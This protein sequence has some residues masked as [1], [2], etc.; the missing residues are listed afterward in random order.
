LAQPLR[1]ANEESLGLTLRFQGIECK[2]HIG[3][4]VVC[5]RADDPMRQ[6]AGLVAE[7]LARLI[8]LLGDLGGR[9][10]VLQVDRSEGQA[11]TREGLR[12]VIPA[13]LLH[14]LFQRFGDQLL[15]FLGRGPRPGGDHGHLLDRERGVFCPAQSQE[16]HDAGD[17]DRHDQEQSDRALAYGE[18]GEVEGAHCCPPLLTATLWA[19]APSA[20]RTCSPSC[21]RSAPSTTTRL[22]A[23][24]PP[25]PVAASSL[26]PVTCTARQVTRGAFPSTSHTPGPLPGSKIAPI[27]T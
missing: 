26:R 23:L 4:F 12:P 19:A 1:L 2:G 22:P 25:T 13:Q 24:R 15:H 16:S 10:A 18:G 14:P 5:H 7:F 9:G 6:L 3:V 27:G 8:E 11:R 17:E 20:S 21:S